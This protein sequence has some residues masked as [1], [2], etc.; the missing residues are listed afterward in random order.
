MS[1]LDLSKYETIFVDMDGVI[2]MQERLI[3]KADKALEE[4]KDSVDIYILSNNDT[5]TRNQIADR[6]C[7]FGLNLQPSTIINSA[8]ILAKYLMEQRGTSKVFVLGEKGLRLELETYGHELVQPAEAEVIAVGTERDIT[9][10]KFDRALTALLKGA[11]FYVANADETFPTGDGEVPGAGA[12]V[13]GIKGMGF[14]PDKYACKP[15]VMVAETAMEVAG[16]ANPS[17]CLLI[18]DRLDVDILMAQKLGMDSALVF[19]GAEN[20]VG[21]EDSE[22]N[23]TYSF[24]SLASLTGKQNL[25]GDYKP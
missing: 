7:K 1:I 12:T 11:K 19:T 18:G 17:N 22:I 16:V 10:E 3:P 13:G 4:L 24:E 5:K 2:L 21:L 25:C 15:S 6:L 23:P 14:M 9:Y 20:R 8:F